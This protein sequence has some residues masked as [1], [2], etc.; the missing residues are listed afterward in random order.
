MDDPREC[1][2]GDGAL[3]L[4]PAEAGV[5]SCSDDTLEPRPQR[6][7]FARCVLIDDEEL[8]MMDANRI[9]RD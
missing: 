3:L 8:R 6:A 4:L 2:G 5:G 9:D 7:S 1:R